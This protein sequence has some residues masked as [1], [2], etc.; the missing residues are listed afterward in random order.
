[1]LAASFRLVCQYYGG[2]GARS[3]SAMGLICLA[4]NG[5]AIFH[6]NASF[7]G[8]G[9]RLIDNLQKRGNIGVK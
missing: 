6:R 3:I 1:M 8:D 4:L 5:I 2:E 9:V 7:S